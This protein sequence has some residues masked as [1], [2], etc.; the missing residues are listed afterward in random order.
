[1]S[2]LKKNQGRSATE[3]S[4]LEEIIMIALLKRE[5]YGLQIVKAIDEASCGKRCLSVGSLYPTLHRM[6]KNG[7]IGSFWGDEK[8]E[9]R[10][11]ARRRYYKLT[12]KGATALNEAQELRTNLTAWQPS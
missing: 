9:E 6:E 12:G 4:Q 5:L 7:L 1:M 11:G 3:I 10:G 2:Q 8:S